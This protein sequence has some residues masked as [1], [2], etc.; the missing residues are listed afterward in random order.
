MVSK[1]NS[2]TI[3][4]IILKGYD[5]FPQSFVTRYLKI[6]SDDTFSL[7]EIKEKSKALNNLVFANQMRDPE[8]LFSKDSTILYMYLEKTKSNTFDG[9]L[10]F[11]TNESNGK[12][13][14]DGYL[15]LNL[16]NNLNYGESLKLLYKSDEN[17][18]QTFDLKINAPYILKHLLVLVL[19][20]TF[21]KE[22]HPLP[23][24]RK[25]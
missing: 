21:S 17:D 25:I 24:L 2:R 1:S 20:L 13:E 9:F 19:I 5:K 22:I 23:P 10:G 16:T 15:N 3:N 12:I 18:Q 14:F 8:V 4:K 11:G 6:K 7:D